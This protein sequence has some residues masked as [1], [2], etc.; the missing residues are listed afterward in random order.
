[1]QHWAELLH[2]TVYFMRRAGSDCSG[3]VTDLGR[4]AGVDS[5]FANGQRVWGIAHGSLGTAVTSP[6]T[7]LV[8]MPPA[9]EAMAFSALPTAFATAQQALLSVGGIGS[10]DTVLIH[11]AAGAVGLAALQARLFAYRT[12][13][14]WSL[15]IAAKANDDQ[16][17]VDEQHV[18]VHLSLMESLGV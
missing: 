6:A 3:I 11:T 18:A 5:G 1:M 4:A 2:A 15:S 12:S 10:G 9:G 16:K 7:T 8:A 13:T 17:C 14:S